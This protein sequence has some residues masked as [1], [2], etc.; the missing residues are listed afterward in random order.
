MNTAA[1]GISR[2]ALARADESRLAASIIWLLDALPSSVRDERFPGYQGWL[3]RYLLR[4]DSVGGRRQPTPSFHC[5]YGEQRDVAGSICGSSRSGSERLPTGSADAVTMLPSSSDPE[6]VLANRLVAGTWLLEGY[7][8]LPLSAGEPHMDCVILHWRDLSYEGSPVTDDEQPGLRLQV[9]IEDSLIRNGDFEELVSSRVATGPVG[10]RIMFDIQVDVPSVLRIVS[11]P[12]S[13]WLRMESAEEPA[14]LYT[15]PVM[16]AGA[17][18]LLVGRMR[19]AGR[20]YFGLMETV[21]GHN[22]FVLPT[23]GV[24]AAGWAAYAAI[25][26]PQSDDGIFVYMGPSDTSS[27]CEYDDLALYRIDL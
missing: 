11:S 17:A 9:M 16:S 7:D 14:V 21:G 1:I 20:C 24:S 10:Y 12:E 23:R 13:Q 4:W 3:D 25:I 19:A 5:A 2:V 15:H 18:H 26:T 8:R 27:V 22:R 6:H